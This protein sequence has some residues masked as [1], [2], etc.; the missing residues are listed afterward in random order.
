MPSDQLESD[1]DIPP[2]EIILNFVSSDNVLESY[3]ASS[4]YG[5][6]PSSRRL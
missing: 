3:D 2:R 5:K 1:E 6:E 4:R